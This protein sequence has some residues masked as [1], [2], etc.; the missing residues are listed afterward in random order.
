MWKYGRNYFNSEET[1]QIE[2]YTFID[3]M[4]TIKNNCEEDKD[5]YYKHI[6]TISN[7]KMQT[8]D[9]FL[10]ALLHHDHDDLA[11]KMIGYYI[12]DMNSELLIYCLDHG[13]EKFFNKS[14]ELIA[15]NKYLFKEDHVADKL[16]DLLKSGSN[17]IYYLNILTM[18]D[19]SLWKTSK[20]KE[21]LHIF[22]AYGN[23][24][25]EKNQVLLT[26]N[27]LMTIAL[28]CEVLTQIQKNRKKLENQATKAKTNLL[29]LGQ[30]YS[31]KI[32]DE[33]FYESLVTDTDFRNRSLLKIITDFEFEP[34]MDEN[35]PKAESIMMSIY[36]GK[37][38]AKCDGS[39]KGYSSMFHVITTNPKVL[40]GDKFNWYKFAK[41]YFEPNYEFDYNF[42]YRYRI[43]SINY[44]F[45][46]E[47]FCAL[48]ILVIFQYINYEYLSLF[49]VSSLENMEY[50]DK[51]LKLQEN[52]DTYKNY[53]LIAFLFSFSLIAH[54]FLKLT[55]NTFSTTG[56]LPFDK[57]TVIDNIS[58]VLYI[59]A[60]I[61]V[62]NLSPEDFLNE[63]TKDWIDYFVLLVLCVTWIRFF[64]FFLVIRDISKL[65]LTL[66]A[67]ITDTLAFILIVV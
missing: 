55:F 67:M 26:Y 28:T 8:K 5:E 54:T 3:L 39:I 58:A 30:M 57:W 14:L 66:V 65:L 51:I 45:W 20:L 32:E 1:G 36:Q 9:N 56:L 63:K 42:Q 21:L 23:Q 48:C 38:T 19:I 62:N 2:Q 61:L 7:W 17:T 44:I 24:G 13:K 27:P 25:F 29:S 12:G 49:D 64:S 50:N 46:K 43:Q 6:Q 37:E 15:F 18:I 35:D 16:L 59:G 52:I 47:F 22:E 34:L 60:I 53:N 41:N 31:S 40:S 10:K 33:E 11:I 4:N